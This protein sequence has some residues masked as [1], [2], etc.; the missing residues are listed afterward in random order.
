MIGNIKMVRISEEK[1]KRIMEQILLTLYENFPKS[2]FTAEISRLVARDEEFIKSLMFDL[3]QKGL[4]VQIRKNP[5]GVPYS[6]RIRW[7]LSNK[8]QDT[9]KQLQ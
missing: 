9:Y 8:A 1:K 2:L 6:R 7:R 5:K 3:K 4:V